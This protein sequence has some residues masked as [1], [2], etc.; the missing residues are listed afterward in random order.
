L[1]VD[2]GSGLRDG[3][4]TNGVDNVGVRVSANPST[5]PAGCYVAVTGI[6][7]CFKDNGENIRRKLLPLTGGVQILEP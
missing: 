6:S 4:K 1:Y 2:D 3:T 5:Y 7:S